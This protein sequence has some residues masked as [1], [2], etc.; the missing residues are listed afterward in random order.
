MLGRALRGGGAP[1]VRAVKTASTTATPAL[2]TN[3]SRQ[4]TVASRPP[5]SGASESAPVCTLA[6]VPIAR[7]SRCGGTISASVASRSG[8]RNALEAPCRKRAATKIVSVGAA[9]AISEAI[10]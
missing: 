6:N 3:A 5:I 2:T 4:C 1:E 10:A 9:A 8:V 7:V